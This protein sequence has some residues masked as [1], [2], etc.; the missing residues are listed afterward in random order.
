M[1]NG[2]LAVSLT[3]GLREK[4]VVKCYFKKNVPVNSRV[5]VSYLQTRY[6]KDVFGLSCEFDDLD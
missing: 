3:P 1:A 2:K 4:D 6:F 5:N